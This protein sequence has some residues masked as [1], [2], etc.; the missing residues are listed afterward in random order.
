MEGETITILWN[1]ALS[2]GADVTYTVTARLNS[3]QVHSATT[4]ALSLQVTRDQLQEMVDIV[5]E[6]SYEVT[7]ATANSAG[8]G[9]DATVTITIPSGRDN[10][11]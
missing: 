11:S 8:P 5:R 6:T 1:E 10:I 9:G 3:Q 2:N 7:V 4:T